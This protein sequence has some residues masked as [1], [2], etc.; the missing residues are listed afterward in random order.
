MGSSEYTL[1]EQF[2]ALTDSIWWFA[3]QHPMIGVSISAFSVLANWALFRYHLAALAEHD[4]LMQNLEVAGRFSRPT[5]DMWM[6]AAVAGGP[7]GLV[8]IA[9]TLVTQAKTVP[10]LACFGIK[11]VGLMKR[12]LVARSLK[13][14]TVLK[15]A[16][17]SFLT[18]RRL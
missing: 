1:F 17:L 18:R 2:V 13:K 5:Y 11:G 15:H 9:F 16:N 8:V 12:H 3:E 7:F 4:F 14:H 10:F 6:W